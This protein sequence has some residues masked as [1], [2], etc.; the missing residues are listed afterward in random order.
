[1]DDDM[2]FLSWGRFRQTSAFGKQICNKNIYSTSRTM[3]LNSLSLY[4]CLAHANIVE[5]FPVP[6]GP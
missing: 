4:S 6:G 3:E 5:V 2:F 1:M